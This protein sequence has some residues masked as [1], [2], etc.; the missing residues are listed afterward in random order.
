LKKKTR[1]SGDVTPAPVQDAGKITFLHIPRNERYEMGKKMRKNCPRTSHAKWEP[2][3]GR[4]DPIDLIQ[5]SD[6]GRIPRPIPLR[7]GRMAR[8]PFTFYRGAALNMTEDLAN[9]PNSGIYVQACGD[10][11][12]CNF[13][14][15]AA[16]ERNV[17]FSINDLDETLPAPWEWDLK[18]LTTSFVAA[19]RNN[20]LKEEIAWKTVLECVRSYRENMKTFSGMKMMELW[21]FFTHGGQEDLKAEGSRND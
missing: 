5:E 15:F 2:V 20:N 7:H 16:P 14:G 1:T 13:A 18:R 11:H 12:L 3:K 4:H 9:T 21:H 6:K 17:I 8:T 10:A 19:C